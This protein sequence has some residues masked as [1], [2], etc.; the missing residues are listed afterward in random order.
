MTCS[1]GAETRT[2]AL[3]AWH[4]RDLKRPLTLL[5]AIIGFA[6]TAPAAIVV[7]CNVHEIGHAIVAT[8]LGWEVERINLCLPAGGSVEYARIGTRAG[9]LEGYAG[10]FIAA[11]LL[12]LVYLFVIALPRRPLRTP[13]WWASGLGVIVWV[14]VQIV[15]GVLEGA[16]DPGHD[17]TDDFRDAPALLL[18][19]A[20]VIMAGA[21]VHAWLWR[22]VFRAP[23]K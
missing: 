17:Y 6:V 7:S 2:E 5:S 23:R 18:L 16:A 12:A 14:G 20:A 19:V 13:V 15:I 22:S 8:P 10:G 21:F 4:W 3:P 9:N 1:T 11:I